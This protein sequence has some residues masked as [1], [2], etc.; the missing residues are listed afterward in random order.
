MGI[1][2]RRRRRRKKEGK[3]EGRERRGENSGGV[4]LWLFLTATAIYSGKLEI[5]SNG[6][7]RVPLLSKPE[8][9]VRP[10]KVLKLLAMKCLERM[11]YPYTGFSL[12]MTRASR[13][14]R[15]LRACLE[16][17]G[18]GSHFTCKTDTERRSSL[19]GL[20]Q[21]ERSW[22]LNSGL[23]RPAWVSPICQFWGALN[24]PPPGVSVW[25]SLSCT[26]IGDCLLRL[27]R[28][29]PSGIPPSPH[30]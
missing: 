3:E 17:Q 7:Q 13:L 10:N 15:P 25:D 18:Q 8:T 1:G 2:D 4:T 21:I 27:P 14:A 6:T 26:S 9:S 20:Q 12:V 16:N 5:S 28:A 30:P 11:T 22:D 23:L 19:Q 29:V 24:I